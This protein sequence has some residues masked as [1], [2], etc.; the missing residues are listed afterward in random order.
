MRVTESPSL[1]SERSERGE[2]QKIV[3]VPIFVVGIACQ[4]VIT[5]QLNKKTA[6][7]EANAGCQMLADQKLEALANAMLLV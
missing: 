7:A 1:R 2:D 6:S 3:T 4:N 5:I